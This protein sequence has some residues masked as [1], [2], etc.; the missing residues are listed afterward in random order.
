MD[1]DQFDGS[2]DGAIPRSPPSAALF[3]KQ[4]RPSSRNSVNAGQCF[5]M[6]WMGFGEVVPAPQLAGLLAHVGPEIV[7]QRMGLK[8]RRTTPALAGSYR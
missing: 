8:A 5:S 7:D 4:T 2:L 3:D 1:V 6:Y